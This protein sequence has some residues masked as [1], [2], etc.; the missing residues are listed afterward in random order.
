MHH[1]KANFKINKI[2]WKWPLEDEHECSDVYCGITWQ[3]FLD[4]PTHFSLLKNFQFLP[5]IYTN[6]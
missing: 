5:Y 1:A 4:S 3:V 6:K 2:L